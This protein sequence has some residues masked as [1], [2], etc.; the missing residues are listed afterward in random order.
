MYKYGSSNFLANQLL[1]LVNFINNRIYRFNL[2]VSIV[3][4]KD[5]VSKFNSD[6]FFKSGQLLMFF[7]IVNINNKSRG[8]IKYNNSKFYIYLPLNST[9]KDYMNN[10]TSEDIINDLI[11]KSTYNE[12][13]LPIELG[14]IIEEDLMEIENG[15][16]LMY[17]IFINEKMNLI[18]YL[19]EYNIEDNY[20]NLIKDIKLLN[21]HDLEIQLK[22][23]RLK[24]ENKLIKNE[25]I[26][27]L[28]N[29]RENHDDFIEHSKMV[30]DLLI[31][32]AIIALD[33]NKMQL[34]WM[35]YINKKLEPIK[36]RNIYLAILFS[37]IGK[38]TSEKYYLQIA[39]QSIN[40]L[41]IVSKD[42]KGNY[43]SMLD[44]EY[45]EVLK[46]LYL[47]NNYI[48]FRELNI[49]IEENKDLFDLIRLEDKIKC[50]YDTEN[51][52]LESVYNKSLD[53]L[54]LLILG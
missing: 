7:Y 48:E 9:S 27:K 26:E 31:K 11:E 37:Y 29:C 21:P 1:L 35:G 39:K 45:Y 4:N 23:I 14:S 3:N 34:M 20:S 42:L 17:K 40:P 44:N 53:L 49:F 43:K 12:E 18:N 38:K 2:E 16:E 6:I 51:L 8:N 5:I 36:Y 33:N 25:L 50:N 32:N 24:F 46:L 47:L 19:N 10:T 54:S 15:F 30:L 52:I 28:I 13:F 22:L 41:L